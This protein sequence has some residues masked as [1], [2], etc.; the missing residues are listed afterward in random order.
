MARPSKGDR[1][2]HMVKVHPAVIPRLV[3]K[4][5]AAGS[6]SVTQYVADVLALH[7]RLPQHVRELNSQSALNV[8]RPLQ[9]LR[10]D[11]Y[12]RIMVR[13]HREVSECLTA[14]APG[15]KAPPHIADILSVHVGLP[16][17]ARNLNHGEEV[18]P[19][20]M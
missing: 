8:P 13:P 18:L 12:G 7:A 14:Q 11:V 5:A 20:A 15:H 9:S 2:A 17:H 6:S 3:E 19:L 1:A 16:E 10:G 4:A